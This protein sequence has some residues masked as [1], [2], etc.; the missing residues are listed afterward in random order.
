MLASR[1]DAIPDRHFSL[2]VGQIRAVNVGVNLDTISSSEAPSMRVLRRFVPILRVSASPFT[3]RRWGLAALLLASALA[4]P[5]TVLAA[6]PPVITFTG[7]PPNPTSNSTPQFTYTVDSATPTTNVCRVDI[8]SFA[9]CPTTVTV[10]PAVLDG[11]HSFTVQATDADGNVGENSTL[12]VVDTTPPTVQLSSSNPTVTND[13]T[14]TFD[15]TVTDLHAISGLTVCRLFDG[16]QQQL[17]ENRSPCGSPYTTPALVEGLY[18]LQVSATDAAGNQGQDAQDFTI[19]L[20]PPTVTIT[21][22]PPEP[23]NDTTPTFGFTT[24]GA[25][26]S[27]RCRIDGTAAN[28][29]DCST[30]FTSPVAIG[31]GAHTFHVTV[32][33]AAGNSATASRAFTVD[34]MPPDTVILS[35]E[36]SRTNHTTGTF[37]FSSEAGTTFECRLDQGPFGACS[38]A[39]DLVGTQQ[40]GSHTTGTLPEGFH[41][42]EVG[43]TDAA[44]NVD[45]TP[46]SYTWFIDLTPPVAAFAMTPPNPSNNATPQFLFS[47]EPGATFECKIDGASFVSCAAAYTVP[48]PLASTTHTMYVRAIDSVGNVQVTPTTFTWTVDLDPPDTTI[49]RLG[50]TP[51]TDVVSFVLTSNESATFECNLDGTGFVAC[52]SSFTTPSLSDGEHTLI[53]RAIDTAGNVDPSPA[54]HTWL[55]DTTPPDTFILSGPSGTSNQ[56][57]AI[58]EFTATE[59]PATFECSLDGAGFTACTSPFTTPALSDGPHTFAVRA[60]DAANRVDDSPATRTW[61]LDT[62][63][64][65]AGGPFVCKAPG[66]TLITIR[67]NAKDAADK[68]DFRWALGDATSSAEL[69][70][71]TVDT[72]YAVCV[73]DDVGGTPTLVMVMN[74]PPAGNC[75][76]RPCWR[77]IRD[78]KAVRYKDLGLLPNGVR[79]LTIGSGPF[80]KASVLVKGRGIHLPDPPMPFTQDPTITVQVVNGLGTCWGADFVVAPQENS[81]AK[82]LVKEKP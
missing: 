27:T 23:T 64:L 49:T 4:A 41:T 68:F 76:G 37:A 30:N 28:D 29:V 42:F 52:A 72:P 66:T 2:A 10:N 65:C 20:T 80:G 77:S 32:T 45:P 62:T 56:P 5:E 71:P 51:S 9:S 35:G 36:P 40:V 78:G 43:A 31:T 74:A 11:T 21:D 82:L 13:Q 33:D 59:Q 6:S 53:V 3:P 73:W 1:F 58:F 16:T 60:I 25:P 46:A 44:G 69:G 81:A 12:F 63:S 15:F 54:S 24:G 57:V 38:G 47:S 79:Q 17:L 61:T 34:T 22:F 8:G 70:D 18:T 55:V 26:V 14:P 48:D 75:G 19:D 50:S 39:S 67:N 7:V